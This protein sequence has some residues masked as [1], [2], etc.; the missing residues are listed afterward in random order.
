MTLVKET[1][2]PIKLSR[3]KTLRTDLADQMNAFESLLI[4]HSAAVEQTSE[5]ASMLKMLQANFKQ[6]QLSASRVMDNMSSPGKSP[7]RKSPAKSKL[8]NENEPMQE[9]Q[10][11]AMSFSSPTKKSAKAPSVDVE[12]NQN[13]T[14]NGM[15][16]SQQRK[17]LS[18]Q[19]D[20]SNDSSIDQNYLQAPT[21]NSSDDEANLSP[22]KRAGRN[23]PK[24]PVKRMRKLE[25][26]AEEAEVQ[27]DV[28]T[29][30]RASPEKVI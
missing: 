21:Q 7:K 13:S 16:K 3:S 6:V 2:S 27:V 23:C 9:C 10:V 18:L 8:V 30:Y 1:S 20:E 5:M 24:S 25:E 14:E 26:Q 29:A 15:R 11:I 17:R 22:S 19:L 28:E 12:K 4:K